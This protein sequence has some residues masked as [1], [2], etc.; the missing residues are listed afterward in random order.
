MG[1]QGIQPLEFFLKPGY[2]VAHSEDTLIRC[3]LG[4]CVAVTMYD[5]SQRVGGINHFV[6]PRVDEKSKATPM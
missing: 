1:Q 4:S 3:V 5:P 2:I 6:W